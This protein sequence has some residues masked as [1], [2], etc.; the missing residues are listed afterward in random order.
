MA[1][2]D[3][4]VVVALAV[5]L[6]IIYISGSYWKHKKLNGLAHWFQERYTPIANVQFRS[7][8]HAGLRVKCEMKDRSSGF[9][10]IYFALSLGARENLMYYPLAT[11]TD[12]LD[13]VNCWGIMEKPVKPNLFVVRSTDRNRVREAE[14]RANMNQLSS[15]DIGDIGYVAYA[16]DLDSAA[17]FLSRSSLATRLKQLGAIEV[18]ELDTLSS[19]VRAVS[20]LEGQR[21]GEF[22]DFVLSLGRAL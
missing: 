19:L 20:K 12:N 4:E 7:F 11:I 17:R 1:V 21:L 14:S 3:V 8:G 18:V 6:I 15:K 5:V 2:T 9:R 16:S 13:R 10:E 22:C